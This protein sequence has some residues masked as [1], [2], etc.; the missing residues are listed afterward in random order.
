M[1]NNTSEIVT[2]TEEEIIYEIVDDILTT[3]DQIK[4]IQYSIKN[5]DE[6]KG[7][8]L[9]LVNIT[10][11]IERNISI[12]NELK[13]EINEKKSEF[14][15]YK[16]KNNIKIKKIEDIIKKKKDEDELKNITIEFNATENAKRNI[17]N[18]LMD[19]INE[20]EEITERLLMLKEEKENLNEQL[21]NLISEKESLE[22]ICKLYIQNFNSNIK[23]IN[24]ADNINNNIIKDIDINLYHFEICKIDINKYC[25]DISNILINAINQFYSPD[26]ENDNNFFD[27]KHAELVN[28]IQNDLINFIE[29]D[30][31]KVNSEIIENFFDTLGNKLLNEIQLEIPIEK[32]IKLLKYLII[33]KLLFQIMLIF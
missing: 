3:Q 6:T 4:N 14:N 10:N 24:G 2:G 15:E 33:M 20:R 1:L 18:N 22:E 23:E 28:I 29:L 25:N 12:I 32:I 16:I 7:S 31:K 5:I 26:L 8:G 13:N 27:Y 30:Y 11:E 17:E 19:K 21:I 9:Q